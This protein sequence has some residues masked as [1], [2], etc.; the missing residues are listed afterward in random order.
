MKSQNYTKYILAIQLFGA[1]MFAVACLAYILGLPLD[2][3]LHEE[4]AYRVAIGGFG[5]IF[6]AGSVVLL[7]VAY[8]IRNRFIEA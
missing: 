2:E 8:V 4:L 7:A 6:F 5:S 3:V 1:L